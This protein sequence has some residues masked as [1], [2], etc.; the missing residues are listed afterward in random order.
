[1]KN[2]RVIERRG[3]RGGGREGR[4]DG[5]T[6][7]PGTGGETAR[8]ERRQRMRKKETPCHACMGRTGKGRRALPNWQGCT[9]LPTSL[10]AS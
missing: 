2:E 3:G 10:P 5:S 6:E 7:S 4:T 1:M 8:G 9:W